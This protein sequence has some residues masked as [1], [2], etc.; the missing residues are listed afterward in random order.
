MTENYVG[1]LSNADIVMQNREILRGCG[2]SNAQIEEFSRR[3][4]KALPKWLRDKLKKI[5][6]QASQSQKKKLNPSAGEFQFYVDSSRF[7][8]LMD[9]NGIPIPTHK[10]MEP[11]LK[12]APL[13][14][15]DIR[16]HRHGI[17]LKRSTVKTVVKQEVKQ[18]AETGNRNFNR[19]RVENNRH[20]QGKH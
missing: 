12:L 8:V 19:K 13:T 2:C 3:E 1:S 14:Q 9:K 18:N 5:G 15:E 6:T 16:T 17:Q 10:L 4:F 11:E 7:R 20:S